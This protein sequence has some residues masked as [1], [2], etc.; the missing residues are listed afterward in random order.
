MYHSALSLQDRNV[1]DCSV[2]QH[3]KGATT[4]GRSRAMACMSASP[5]TN[6]AKCRALRHAERSLRT[7][8]LSR[9][10]EHRAGSVDEPADDKVT[11]S[12]IA[13]PAPARSMPIWRQR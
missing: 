2:H 9:A 3:L 11:E 5:K 1:F 7:S 6:V 13:V 12:I 8:S 4:A 10:V